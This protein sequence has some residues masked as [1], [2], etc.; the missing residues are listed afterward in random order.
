MRIAHL[1]NCYG[2][3]SG[4]LRT[5]M[6]ELARGYRAAGHEVVLVVP[7]ARTDDEVT[8]YGRRITVRAPVVPGTGGYRMIVDV[9]DVRRILDGLRPD[10]LEVSDRTT[11][12]GLGGWAAERRIASVVFAH[13]RVDRILG[14][15]LLATAPWAAVADRL[16]ARVGRRFGAVVATTEFAATEWV[17][18][19]AANLVR[20][21]LGV[22]LET[23]HPRRRDEALR[24]R[25]LGDAKV[26]LVQVARLSPE[27]QPWVGVETLRQLRGR[28]VDAA[29]VLAGAGP[30]EQS[31]RR[32]AGRLPVRF[33]GHVSSRSD[34]AAILASSDLAV[35]PAPHETFGL[36]ALE[37]LASGTPCV[38]SA[39]SA[40]PAL[41]SGAGAAAYEPADFSLA[42]DLLL[43]RDQDIMRRNARALA[44]RY[45]WS[46]TVERMLALH[47]S[48]L[49]QRTARAA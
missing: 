42:A 36:G 12:G 5:T 48:L 43:Q 21:P 16:N 9:G 13:E 15:F 4:G 2:P 30:K 11:L 22:D 20:I 24:R 27:K 31:L 19:G 23:F 8:A 3:R 47:R 45:P 37:A 34:L 28:H 1:A 10:V 46:V 25:L 44:S 38:V 35:V 26:L 29:L 39:Q 41:V 17:R 40:L 7:G 14:Q 18:V 49:D 32:R 6:H 33:L